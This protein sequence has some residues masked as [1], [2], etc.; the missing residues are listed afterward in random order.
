MSGHSKWSS[1]KHKKAA[2]DAKRGKIF[3]KIIREITVAAKMGGPDPD[4]NPRLRAAV[5][6]ARG[7]NM[8]ND[9]VTRAIKKGSGGND[10]VEYEEVIYEGFG[11]AN[12]AVVIQALTDNRNRTIAS[13][14]TAFNKYNGSLGPANSVQFMFDRMGSILIPTSVVDEDTLTEA[15]LDAGGDD[16]ELVDDHFQVL[17]SLEN[18]EAV[19]AAMEEKGWEAKESGLVQVPQNKTL[20]SN[21][22]EAEKVMNFIDLLE[23]DDD[24][25]KVFTNFDVDD[26]LLAEFG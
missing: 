18:F 26:A 1:I 11:P 8:P 4:A 19:K 5:Q 24:V 20:I 22:E 9:T 21:K 14:R 2:V 23:E 12:V 17:C 25:Q 6:N 13:I 3:T 7:Q 16:L 10:G 15:V